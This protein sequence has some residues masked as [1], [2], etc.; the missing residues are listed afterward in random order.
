MGYPSST[1]G[2]IVSDNDP[3]GS[4]LP[5]TMDIRTAYVSLVVIGIIRLARSVADQRPPKISQL[6]GILWVTGQD[7]EE[8]QRLQV[9]GGTW[10]KVKEKRLKLKR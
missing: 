6:K 3:Y 2:A 5:E 7:S 10:W 8:E 9:P 4:H 1:H